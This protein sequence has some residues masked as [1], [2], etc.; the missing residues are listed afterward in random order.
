M[1]GLKKGGGHLAPNTELRRDSF[2]NERGQSPSPAMFD[3]EDVS[4]SSS[5]RKKNLRGAGKKASATS[6]LGKGRGADHGPRETEA[7]ESKLAG[8]GTFLQGSGKLRHA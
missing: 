5:R 1:T 6:R 3:S 2:E 7:A 8:K 4:A